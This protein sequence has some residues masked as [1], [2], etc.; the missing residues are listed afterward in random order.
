LAWGAIAFTA[1]TSSFYVLRRLKRLV[2]CEI[3]QAMSVGRTGS[4]RP[5]RRLTPRPGW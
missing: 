4:A 3:R 5:H 1:V 2:A